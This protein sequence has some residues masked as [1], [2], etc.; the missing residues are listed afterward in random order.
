MATAPELFMV[1]FLPPKV[2][3]CIIIDEN[4]VLAQKTTFKGFNQINNVTFIQ[5]SR[6][7]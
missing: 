7:S 2:K 3:Y 6:L 1:C 4:G 5:V